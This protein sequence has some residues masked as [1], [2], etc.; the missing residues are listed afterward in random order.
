MNGRYPNGIVNTC[1][2]NS[3]KVVYTKHIRIV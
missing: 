1:H 3:Q 2:T